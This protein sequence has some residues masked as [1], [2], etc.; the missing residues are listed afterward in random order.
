MPFK[1]QKLNQLNDCPAFVCNNTEEFVSS[2]T[3]FRIGRA[4]W[5]Q[6]VLSESM[7]DL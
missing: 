2:V 6:S 7:K 5:G 3:F 1:F 4:E